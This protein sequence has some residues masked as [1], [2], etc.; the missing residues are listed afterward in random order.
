MSFFFH[1]SFFS[2]KQKQALELGC[3]SLGYVFIYALSPVFTVVD[4]KMR[5]WW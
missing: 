2:L 3:N 5:L 1:S 4:S